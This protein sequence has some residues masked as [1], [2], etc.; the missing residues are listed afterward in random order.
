[1]VAQV[2]GDG[3]EEGVEL[4]LAPFGLDKLQCRG[5]MKALGQTFDL[6]G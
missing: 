5:R 1:L 2:D 3:S 4:G 6:I